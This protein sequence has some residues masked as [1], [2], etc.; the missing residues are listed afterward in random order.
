MA[1]II[2]QVECDDVAC[3]QMGH[4]M[5]SRKRN[6]KLD[7]ECSFMQFCCIL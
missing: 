1:L 5:K 3:Y 6:L 7:K 2:A 4:A